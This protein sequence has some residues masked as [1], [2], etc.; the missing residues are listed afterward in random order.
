MGGLARGTCFLDPFR[1]GGF[2]DDLWGYA[3]DDSPEKIFRVTRRE[4]RRTSESS[5]TLRGVNQDAKV[6][7]IPRLPRVQIKD[8]EQS[9]SSNVCDVYNVLCCSSHVMYTPLML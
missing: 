3:H 5:S 8:D 2:F 9:K 4:M 1:G 6:A 7:D